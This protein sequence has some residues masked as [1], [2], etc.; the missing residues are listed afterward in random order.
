M[1]QN[2]VTILST[3]PD[4]WAWWSDARFPRPVGS[5]YVRRRAEQILIHSSRWHNLL[6]PYISR[7]YHFSEYK[8]T[9]QQSSHRSA[10]HFNH[11][12]ARP[13]STKCCQAKSF[14]S[15]VPTN[16]TEARPT[17]RTGQEQFCHLW[18]LWWIYQGPGTVEKPH[19]VDSQGKK[20]LSLR[21]MD[22][23]SRLNWCY[24]KTYLFKIYAT[25]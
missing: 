4:Q 13:T 12:T 25:N 17:F 9:Q 18:N 1:T 2:V 6:P 8:S 19:A 5:T 23:G 3:L 24:Q 14:T 20:M 7:P 16:N 15:T 22:V 10:E 21:S 11:T